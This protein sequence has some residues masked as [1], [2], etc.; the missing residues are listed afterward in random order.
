MT[1]ELQSLL[2]KIRIDGIEKAEA[3]RDE[4]IRKA[5]EDTA[6]AVSRCC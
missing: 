6:S 3:Q 2:E 5:Q 4:I 1:E